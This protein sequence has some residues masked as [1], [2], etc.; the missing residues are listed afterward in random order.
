MGKIRNTAL[1]RT[2]DSRELSRRRVSLGAGTRTGVV[3]LDLGLA[4]PVPVDLDELSR[5]AG[6]IVE[7]LEKSKEAWRKVGRE[8]EA[9]S[10]LRPEWARYRI[11]G[12][13][14]ARYVAKRI[15]CTSPIGVP[16]VI[17]LDSYWGETAW[18]ELKAPVVPSKWPQTVM[19]LGVQ[20]QQAIWLWQWHRHGGRAGVFALMRSRKGFD[21]DWWLWI[22]ARHSEEWPALVQA[23]NGWLLLP[24]VVG[25]G[26]V[27]DPARLWSLDAEARPVV[28]FEKPRYEELSTWPSDPLSRVSQVRPP[29]PPLL[30]SSTSSSSSSASEA[31]R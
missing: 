14:R 16:D 20:P 1:P 22:P 10:R 27:P 24:H 2:R 11:P 4:E 26:P 21:R 28:H 15:E 9:W 6:R 17:L 8:T 25:T 18:I 12:S 5:V 3:D 29:V 13:R 30:V 19:K 23:A 7:G 31:D